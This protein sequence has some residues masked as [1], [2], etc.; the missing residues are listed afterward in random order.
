LSLKILPILTA[1]NLNNY[2]INIKR[3]YHQINTKDDFQPFL[4][5]S[6]TEI[7]ETTSEIDPTNITCCNRINPKYNQQVITKQQ[8]HKNDTKRHYQPFFES[9]EKI[10]SKQQAQLSERIFKST[11]ILRI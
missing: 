5:S 4:D 8:R 10:L 2:L 3:Q 7:I 1:L 11:A 6:E 9:N